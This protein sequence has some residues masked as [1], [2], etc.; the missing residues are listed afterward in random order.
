M[1]DINLARSRGFRNLS[2]K[3]N[4]PCADLRGSDKVNG[5]PRVVGIVNCCK[6][7]DHNRLAVVSHGR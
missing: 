7:V 1:P 2:Q 6:V 5:H 3:D 4:F